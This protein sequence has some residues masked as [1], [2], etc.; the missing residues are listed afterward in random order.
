LYSRTRLEA[1]LFNY[2]GNRPILGSENPDHELGWL[3]FNDIR[4]KLPAGNTDLR[5]SLFNTGS[6]KTRI[7]QYESNVPGAF[8]SQMMFGRGI[9]VYA[10]IRLLLQ[11]GTGLSMKYSFMKYLTAESI[12]SGPDH[13]GSLIDR[14]V[15]LQVDIRFN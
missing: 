3:V 15:A 14:R 6:Y 7:Y 8:S 2:Q 1:C 12:K 5:F 4:F 11:K 13:S 10:M 9:R